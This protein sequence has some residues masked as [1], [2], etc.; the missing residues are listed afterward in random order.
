MLEQLDDVFQNPNTL[1]ALKDLNTAVD[2][3]TPALEF[4]APHQTVCNFFNYFIHGLGEH[5]SFTTMGGTVQLQNLKTVNLEQ[6]NTSGQP[7]EQP[8]VGHPDRPRGHDLPV[9]RPGRPV[10]RDLRGRARRPPLRHALPG[11]RST[12]RATRTA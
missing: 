7:G 3:A 1:L 10:R 6:P 11:R 4:I 9:G 2:V 5:M 12:P 8:A